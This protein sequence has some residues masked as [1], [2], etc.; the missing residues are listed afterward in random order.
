M[1][2][3]LDQ[4]QQSKPNLFTRKQL[5]DKTDLTI[6]QVSEWFKRLARPKSTKRISLKTKLVLKEEFSKNEQ[7][8]HLDKIEICKRSQLSIKAVT[9]WFASERFKKKHGKY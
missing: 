9:A 1:Q 4:N 6:A 5:A 8:S 7:P 2:E 3:W